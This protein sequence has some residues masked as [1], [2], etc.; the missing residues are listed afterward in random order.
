MRERNQDVLR[1]PAPNHHIPV[2]A[3]EGHLHPVW[4]DPALPQTPS[5]L[6]E[7]HGILD[8]ADADDDR[9]RVAKARLTSNHDRKLTAAL[10]HDNACR[11]ENPENRRD[12]FGASKYLRSGRA[13]L[14]N[15]VPRLERD[16][17]GPTENGRH[18]PAGIGRDRTWVATNKPR[19][20]KRLTRIPRAVTQ[21][22][23]AKV[24]ELVDAQD[25]GFCG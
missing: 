13:R 1:E 10:D 3:A 25:S 22:A 11:Q 16:A 9:S 24:A 15:P 12:R 4:F 19:T 23:N 5:K 14:D 18:D 7:L 20:C 21:A 17:F 6:L 8:A 2:L